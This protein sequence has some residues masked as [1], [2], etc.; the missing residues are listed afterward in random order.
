[1]GR[2]LFVTLFLL[3]ASLLYSVFVI[4]PFVQAVQFSGYR[5]R[6][7]S[8]KKKFVGFENYDKLLHDSVF[9][10]SLCHNLLI[11]TVCGALI[12]FSSVAVAHAM[13]PGGTV[14]KVLKSVYLFPQVVSLVAV[15]V[16]WQF[17]LNPQGLLNSLLKGAG[18]ANPPSWLGDSRFALAAVALVFAWYVMGFYTM[19]FAAGIQSVPAETFEAAELDGSAGL[20][21]FWRVT[22]PLLWPIKRVAVVYL[23]V[24]VT[25]IFALVA[26]M[27]RGGPD[28]ASEVML[29][30]LYEQAFTNSQ[31]GYATAIGM[32][33]L[34]VI[35][36]MALGI[37]M[38]FRKDPTGAAR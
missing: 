19:L 33:N 29:T 38:Y 12:V 17:V 27:T 34:V 4:V 36:L 18:I 1:M 5:W 26:L 7:L 15:A 23:V 13:R 8:M 3:P 24:N 32:A 11:L 30:Y 16:L 14:A 9:W 20:N 28:R 2:R 25:N 22:W 6:G 10:Q 31:F 35:M 37:M 21:R